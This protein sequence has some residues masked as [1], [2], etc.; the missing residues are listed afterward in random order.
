MNP[1][2]V[3]LDECT[4]KEEE[5]S[6]RFR[7]SCKEEKTSFNCSGK[8][9]LRSRDQMTVKKSKLEKAILKNAYKSKMEEM[10]IR[11]ISNEVQY[12]YD[13]AHEGYQ[14]VLDAR[15]LYSISGSQADKAIMEEAEDVME[16][17]RFRSENTESREEFL[18][19]KH[20]DWPGC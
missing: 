7:V 19:M 1:A 8:K 11:S 13:A 20:L 9:F 5:E 18:K 2:M 12:L 3:T 4:K 10:V 17:L 6:K 16:T 15:R 14:H